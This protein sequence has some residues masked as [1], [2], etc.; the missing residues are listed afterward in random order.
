MPL[1]VLFTDNYSVTT[2]RV[3]GSERRRWTGRGSSWSPPSR[4]SRPRWWTGSSNST[5]RGGTS[6]HS[7]YISILQKYTI[8]SCNAVQH[9]K[10]W[11]VLLLYRIQFYILYIT[12]NICP[13]FFIYYMFMDI[14][15]NAANPGHLFFNIL[16]STLVYVYHC[17]HMPVLLKY[18]LYLCV[19]C[20]C[21]S[22]CCIL[23]TYVYPVKYMDH[24]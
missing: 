17:K 16:Y 20:I 9:S 6:G 24:S 1:L 8:F 19:Y 7:I 5:P 14:L 18:A 4:S 2:R 3:W 15:P 21:T 12:V 13:F 10:H 11:P 23:D 22:F